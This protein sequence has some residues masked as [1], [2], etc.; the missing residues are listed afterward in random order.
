MQTFMDKQ[1]GLVATAAVHFFNWF[2]KD[3]TTGKEFFTSKESKIAAVGW[4]VQM[5][6]MK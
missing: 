5:K 3:D 2:M 6:N 1:G 4:E